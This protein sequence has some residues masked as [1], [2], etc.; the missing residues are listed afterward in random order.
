MSKGGMKAMAGKD[1]GYEESSRKLSARIDVNDR[2]SERSAND[3]VLEM[4][5][6]AEGEQIVDLCCGTSKQCL[7][8][9]QRV[10]A[11]GRVLGLDINPDVLATARKVSTGIEQVS[12]QQHD[13]NDPLPVPDSSIDL[14]SCCFGIYYIADLD[15]L[16]EE[17]LRALEPG[18]RFFVIAP[19]SQNNRRF[20]E[21][22]AEVSG[23]PEPETITIRRMRMEKELLPL[24]DRR[25]ARVDVRNFENQVHITDPTAFMDYYRSTLLLTET[26]QDASVRDDL[27]RRMGERVAAIIKNEGRYTISKSYLAVLA[28]KA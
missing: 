10:G 19:A 8:F 20:R 17:V 12:Y 13:C 2:F 25:F 15:A 14:I 3:L 4:A 21:L 22:H 16:L 7:P 1:L 11:K 6:P 24:L 27:V 23:K 18:G 26:S 9:A 5:A 28:F